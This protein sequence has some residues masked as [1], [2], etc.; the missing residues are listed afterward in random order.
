M[1]NPFHDL[2]Y[3]GVDYLKNQEYGAAVACFSRGL[4]LVKMSFPNEDGICP[5]TGGYDFSC[6][7]TTITTTSWKESGDKAEIFRPVKLKKCGMGFFR[8]C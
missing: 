2:N 4:N 1:T 5:C 7:S 3:D 6:C 8:C